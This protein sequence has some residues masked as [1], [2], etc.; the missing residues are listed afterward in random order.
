MSN[1]IFHNNGTIQIKKLC[2]VPLTKTPNNI[3]GYFYSKNHL[4]IFHGNE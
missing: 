2:I 3:L 4:L 1:D